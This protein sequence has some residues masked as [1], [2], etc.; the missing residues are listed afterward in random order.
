MWS[1]QVRGEYR[2]VLIL[3]S[4]EYEEVFTTACAGSCLQFQY[5]L[6]KLRQEIRSF[7]VNLGYRVRLCLKEIKLVLG[8]WGDVSVDKVSESMCN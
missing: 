4:E 5:L 3:W 7:E 1:A 6:R 8:V 2:D